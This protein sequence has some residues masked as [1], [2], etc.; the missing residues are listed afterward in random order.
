MNEDFIKQNR[1]VKCLRWTNRI[2]GKSFIYKNKSVC[3]QKKLNFN[4]LTDFF[5]VFLEH[6]ITYSSKNIRILL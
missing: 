6:F 3:L 4:T 1:D 5:K 2:E